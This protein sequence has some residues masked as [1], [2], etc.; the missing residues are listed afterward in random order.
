MVESKECAGTTEPTNFRFV[1]N[2]NTKP[3]KPGKRSF[4]EMNTTGPADG[5]SAP[6]KKQ[7]LGENQVDQ[8]LED[9]RLS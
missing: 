1:P 2:N 6:F 5:S 7:K 4:G 9:Y 3:A 8:R